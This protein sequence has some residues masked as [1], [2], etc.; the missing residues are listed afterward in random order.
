MLLESLLVSLA[1]SEVRNV[2]AINFDPTAARLKVLEKASKFG[3]LDQIEEKK[4]S[5]ADIV[6]AVHSLRNLSRE[7]R[8]SASE[9]KEEFARRSV[10]AQ[11]TRAGILARDIVAV[12]PPESAERLQQ[13][14]EISKG[15]ATS[16]WLDKA[17]KVPRGRLLFL[18]VQTKSA[19]RDEEKQVSQLALARSNFDPTKQTQAAA[20]GGIWLGYSPNK[21]ITLE[22]RI[23]RKRCYCADAEGSEPYSR[24]LSKGFQDL[25]VTQFHR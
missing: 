20:K 5:L 16:D 6:T 7:Q 21:A 17:M 3:L 22:V 2:D 11:V 12:G 1:E 24:R 19:N 23:L 25:L 4:K 14:D 15:K 8:F 9:A 18:S 13:L 10:V